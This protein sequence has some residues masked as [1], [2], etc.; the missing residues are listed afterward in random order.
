ML[1]VYQIWCWTEFVER[2]IW[3]NIFVQCCVQQTYE[4]RN[5]TKSENC[6]HFG[7]ILVKVY[8][9]ISSSKNHF[10]EKIL[11]QNLNRSKNTCVTY[12]TIPP[13]VTGSFSA[14]GVCVTVSVCVC[15]CVRYDYFFVHPHD[16]HIL[17]MSCKF[18]SVRIIVILFL[19]VYCLLHPVLCPCYG[20]LVHT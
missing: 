11:F 15:V 18:V 9:L 17:S 5:V 2:N 14:Q 8:F 1:F 13:F 6:L 16:G 10:S 12:G 19:M 4:V 3:Q 7:W 20:L